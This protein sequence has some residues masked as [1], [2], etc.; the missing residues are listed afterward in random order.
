M[1]RFL[2]TFFSLSSSCNKFHLWLTILL[3]GGKSDCMLHPL[4]FLPFVPDLGIW[5]KCLFLGDCKNFFH[6][7]VDVF[8]FM[9]TGDEILRVL[10]KSLSKCCVI[11]ANSP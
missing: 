9:P 2:N 10:L 8:S 6:L 1:G 4:G 3:T 5:S 7:I 11:L